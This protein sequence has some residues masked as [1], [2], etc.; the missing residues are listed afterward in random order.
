MGKLCKLANKAA[1][2]FLTAIELTDTQLAKD[3]NSFLM[4]VGKHRQFLDR[5]LDPEKPLL[6]SALDRNAKLS[7][8]LDNLKPGT[9]VTDWRKAF[10]VNMKGAVRGYAQLAERMRAALKID[11]SDPLFF[12]KMEAGWDTH[13]PGKGDEASPGTYRDVF[14][15]AF[16]EK[17]SNIPD[18]SIRLE[19]LATFYDMKKLMEPDRNFYNIATAYAYGSLLQ[20]SFFD[21]LLQDSKG[22]LRLDVISS[23]TLTM[24]DILSA[25]DEGA[26]RNLLLDRIGGAI[27]SEAPYA[28]EKRVKNLIDNMMG[29]AVFRDPKGKGTLPAI[30]AAGNRVVQE[31][32]QT[33]T[34]FKYVLNVPSGVQMLLQS[35][36]MGI[37]LNEMKAKGLTHIVTHPLVDHLIKEKGFLR[38]ESRIDFDVNVADAH[39]ESFLARMINLASDATLGK[40]RAGDFVKTVLKSG[41]HSMA[42]MVMEADVKR[43][44]VA[45]ALAQAGIMSVKDLD[46][47]LE[48]MTGKNGKS[49]SPEASELGARLRGIASVEYNDFFTNSGIHALSRDKLSRWI[50]FNYMQGYMVKRGDHAIRPFRNFARAI[51]DGRIKTAADA[52]RFARDDYAFRDLVFS[53]G[54]SFKY[55]VWMNTLFEANSNEDR[56]P[57][58]YALLLNDFYQGLTQNYIARMLWSGPKG[59]GDYFEM[60][61]ELGETGTWSEGLKAGA[62]SAANAMV[63]QMFRELKPLNA[64]VVGAKAAIDGKPW[65]YIVRSMQAEIE[66]AISGAGRFNALP[67]WE[68]TGGRKVPQMDDEF[69]YL[70]FGLQ[71]T[72]DSLKLA[73]KTARWESI[74]KGLDD[75]T[76][77]W[78]WL[79]MSQLPIVPQLFA[80]QA[81]SKNRIQYET[82]VNAYE[83]DMAF[84]GLMNG[85]MQAGAFDGKNADAFW[86]DMVKFDLTNDPHGPGLAINK[87]YWSRDD[88]DKLDLFTGELERK[89]GVTN[90]RGAL[91]K[92][93]DDGKQA[94]LRQLILAMDAKANGSA[95]MALSYVAD[96]ALAQAKDANIA[97]GVMKKG[98]QLPPE[99]EMATKIGILEKLWPQ[100]YAADKTSWWKLQMDYLKRNHP[101]EFDASM[102]DEADRNIKGASLWKK[103][104]AVGTMDLAIVSEAKAG[105]ASAAFIRNVSSEAS[106]YVEDPVERMKVL[107]YTLGRIGQLQT[108][109]TDKAALRIGVLAGNVGHMAEI[110]QDQMVRTLYPQELQKTLDTFYG[111]ANAALVETGKRFAAA[112]KPYGSSSYP[113]GSSYPKSSSS[114]YAGN[115]GVQSQLENAMPALRRA[116]PE[117]YAPTVTRSSTPVSRSGYS[118][119]DPRP[120]GF[121]SS[122]PTVNTD[123]KAF[124][125]DL[126]AAVT[127]NLVHGYVAHDPQDVTKDLYKAST[128]FSKPYA[129]A[130]KTKLPKVE[131][132]YLPR[133]YVFL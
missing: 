25:K 63:A 113:S 84:R 50:P 103:M 111:A 89:M 2:A 87:K 62:W 79:G 23:P 112:D 43:T 56:S 64:A 12:K 118:S 125:P 77:T 93:Y 16:A 14:E 13:M 67:G 4:L 78:D 35:L 104:N 117:G 11:P 131:K 9:D 5:V 124:S 101:V 51:E 18:P 80:D 33:S 73:G 6:T 92:A 29:D 60:K 68:G 129:K 81:T 1:D 102:S 96:R 61:G 99:V 114:A 55:A 130:L 47:L 49:L 32:R 54:V 82:Y 100:M 69:G 123:F 26:V 126:K 86:G 30:L 120:E 45:R 42:D 105:N 116:L 44:S 34:F 15:S 31:A 128:Y 52:W 106:K 65:E 57:E 20:G 7:A 37:P 107:R 21:G 27:R 39:G 95:R 40:T 22:S 66:A 53:A 122:L 8:A 70:V 98:E 28:T 58:K 94:E 109:P 115:R 85:K 71:E 75:K 17:M 24:A 41:I 83:N 121:R 88:L 91:D 90:L 110:A 133:K 132:R 38:S 48:A 119:Y 36:V 46:N 3:S 74:L 108:T 72:N 10:N 19:A 59:V 97:A 127:Q 76:G